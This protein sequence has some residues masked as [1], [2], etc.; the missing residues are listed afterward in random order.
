M[1]IRS[2][3]SGRGRRTRTTVLALGL[4]LLA[5]LLLGGAGAH[6]A[7]TSGAKQHPR[8]LYWGAQIDDHLTGEAAPWDMSAVDVFTE[9]T[10]K[11]PSLISFSAPFANC[12]ASPCHFYNFPLSPLN[13]VHDY[14]AIPMFNWSSE[15]SLGGSVDPMFRLRA[16]IDGTFDSYIRY[17]AEEAKKWDHPF[18]LRFDWEMNGFW[19]P[20]SDDANGNNRGEFVEAWRHVH[21]I[22]T[23]AGATNVSWV[24]CPNI[25][26]TGNLEPL[27]TVY[28]GDAYVDWTC[29]DGFNWGDTANSA[30]W[31][32]FKQIFAS[33]YHRVLKIAPDKPMMIGEVAS[34]SRGG[35]KAKW[36]KNMLRIIPARF[37]KI[38]GLVWFETKDQ[39]MRWSLNQPPAAAK[40]FA[41]GIRRHVYRPNVFSWLQPGPIPPPGS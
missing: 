37:R 36:I 12:Q 30:G 27:K 4:A 20:W 11:K 32:T 6:A 31:M 8:P 22:F 33:T 7:N 38:R 29:L 40:A 39:D 9:M 26:F 14:G 3:S 17:F 21:D 10:H 15:G 16:V 34:D 5:S 28:P 19:F 23:A 2:E 35:S 41:G 25:D 24:W 18:F 1:K 13:N